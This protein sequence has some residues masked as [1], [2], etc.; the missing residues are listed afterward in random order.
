MIL[1]WAAP[2]AGTAGTN[3]Y[4]SGTISLAGV[5]NTHT[6][7]G[8]NSAGLKS[9]AP[10][11][12]V[13]DTAVTRRLRWHWHSDRDGSGVDQGAKSVCQSA[14]TRCGALVYTVVETDPGLISTSADRLRPMTLYIGFNTVLHNH[15]C[16][17]MANLQNQDLVRKGSSTGADNKQSFGE[18][19]STTVS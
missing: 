6:S 16:L 1:L 8:L 15:E 18:A 10:Q 13:I 3:N 7:S 2:A 5:Y 4:G 17:A 14:K 11:Q 19:Y 9:T 12:V